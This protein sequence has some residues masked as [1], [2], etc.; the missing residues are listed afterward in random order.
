MNS[1]TERAIETGYSLKEQVFYNPTVISRSNID[2]ST[3][4]P[5]HTYYQLPSGC[6]H[7][8]CNKCESYLDLL[9]ELSLGRV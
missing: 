1:A 4:L 7:Y 5:I 3:Y 6:M 9:V 2:N 8:N